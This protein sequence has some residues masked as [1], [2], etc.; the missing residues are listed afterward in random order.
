MITKPEELDSPI[1]KAVDVI[2]QAE[3]L[4]LTAGPARDPDTPLNRL[5]RFLDYRCN[6]LK[7]HFLVDMAAA[8]GL[9][10]PDAER[11]IVRDDFTRIDPPRPPSID[12][13]PSHFDPESFARFFFD[14]PACRHESDTDLLE[15][16]DRGQGDYPEKIPFLNSVAVLFEDFGDIGPRFSPEQIEQG[17]WYLLGYRFSL[18]ETIHSKDVPLEV[19]QQTIRMMAYPFSHYYAK[20]GEGYPGSA[21]FMWWDLLETGFSDVETTVL[22]VLEQI[23]KLDSKPCQFAALHGLN[24]LFPIARGSALVDHYLAEHR[25]AL[26]EKDI[27]WVEACRDGKAL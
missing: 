13:D 17:L 3:A 26:D 20:V 23:L 6:D 27:A 7:V 11:L 4:K 9:D 8:G 15:A 21:F 18:G 24:H 14:R 16:H 12:L 19:R 2:E 25:S 22:D 10:D 1:Q 5:R